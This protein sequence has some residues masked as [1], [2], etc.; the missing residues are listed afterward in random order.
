MCESLQNFLMLLNL[1]FM[2]PNQIANMS[3]NGLRRQVA[4][5][6]ETQIGTWIDKSSVVLD[7]GHRVLTSGDSPLSSGFPKKRLM[8]DI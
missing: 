7:L 6:D 8:V 2:P 3:L 4:T 1:D 5:H